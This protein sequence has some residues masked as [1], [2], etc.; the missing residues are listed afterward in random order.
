MTRQSPRDFTGRIVD[1]DGSPVPG[2]MLRLTSDLATLGS[3][4][5]AVSNSRGTVT[6]TR[7]LTG[8]AGS[9]WNCWQK[10]VAHRVASITWEEFRREAAQYNPSL[11]DSEDIMRDDWHYFLPENRVRA[12]AVAA[13]DI[14]WDRV[15]SDFDGNLWACWRINL[16]G[17]VVGL[18]WEAFRSQVRDHNPHIPGGEKAGRQPGSVTLPRNRNQD[19]YVR[20]TFAGRDGRFR[21]EA[22]PGGTYRLEV[23]AE[24][25]LPDTRDLTA[26]PE[27]KV[28]IGLQ[29]PLIVLPKGDGFVR[30]AGRDFA[31]DGRRFRFIG[32][33]LRGLVHYGKLPGLP[34]ADARQQ[35]S[36]ARDM[37]ARVIRVFAPHKDV[38][39][40]DTVERMQGLLDLMQAEFPEMYLA[41]SLCNLYSDVDFRVPGDGDAVLQPAAR[42]LGRTHPRPRLVP[43]GLQGRIYHLRPHDC[44]RVS[45]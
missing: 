24:G 32:V 25:Y 40:G 33:N 12:D 11:R 38:A 35:L 37:G 27:G 7:P 3:D 31:V 19:E 41:V 4:P 13:P 17:K 26:P 16:Q 22:L 28:V 6:W 14:V 44:D 34:F 9:L 18:T 15:L 43:G 20:V 30:T 39:P 8:F 29:A 45:R 1:Q 10:Y 21:F 5:R 36:A 2:A 42:R 23:S